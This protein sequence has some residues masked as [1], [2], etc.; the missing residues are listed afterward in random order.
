MLRG[1]TRGEPRRPDLSTSALKRVV[2]AVS[3]GV[4]DVLGTGPLFTHQPLGRQIDVHGLRGY[5][6]DF[7]H[8]AH[9]SRDLEPPPASEPIAV[10]QAGLG[11]WELLLE[12]H[13][14][15]SQF[16][17]H[18]DWLVRHAEAPAAGMGWRSPPPVPKYGLVEPWPSAMAQGE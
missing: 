6:C 11:F 1:P 16:L 4:Q 18:A 17:A 14:T 9:S 10:A 8:K 15:R 5:Y 12:G 3:W 13:D 7:R 2:T